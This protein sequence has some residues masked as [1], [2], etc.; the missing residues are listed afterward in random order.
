MPHPVIFGRIAAVIPVKNIKIS[1]EFYIN[2]LNF[3][4]VFT[5]GDPVGFMIL[6]RE[7]AELHLTLQ[8]HH[9]APSF[10]VAHL[11]VD[12]ANA[13]YSQCQNIGAKIIKGLQDKEYGIRAFVFADPDGNRIDVGQILRK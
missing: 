5:N 12:D 8:P 6:K 13:F 10:P 4:A 2:G 11:L 9:K 7:D 3:N 1:S